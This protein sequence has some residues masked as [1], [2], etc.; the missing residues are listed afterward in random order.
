MKTTPCGKV[1]LSATQTLYS[2]LNRR[3]YSARAALKWTLTDKTAHFSD[4]NVVEIPALRYLT[5]R[6]TN[7]NIKVVLLTFLILVGVK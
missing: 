6:K 4:S 3:E 7:T 1:T 5:V 2:P